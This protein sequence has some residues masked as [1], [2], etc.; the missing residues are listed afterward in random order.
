MYKYVNFFVLAGIA[1]FFQFF[2]VFFLVRVSFLHLVGRCEV[3]LNNNILI[4]VIVDCQE[5]YYNPAYKHEV[6]YHSN[7]KCSW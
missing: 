1:L 5:V 3:L 7:P 6:S 2:V 4:L